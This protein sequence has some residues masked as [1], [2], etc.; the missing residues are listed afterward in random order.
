[1]QVN[2]IKITKI[3]LPP[4]MI[5]FISKLI[6]ATNAKAFAID[7]PVPI[8]GGYQMSIWLWW[9]GD[10]M[11]TLFNLDRVDDLHENHVHIKIVSRGFDFYTDDLIQVLVNV[12]FFADMNE[13][14]LKL[15][16]EVE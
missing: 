1:M 13:L 16:K 6:K 8:I 15:Q 4:Q 3:W 9:T 14:F 5:K 10:V 12:Y 11:Q 2:K 7:E